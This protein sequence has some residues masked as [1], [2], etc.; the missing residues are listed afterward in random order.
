MDEP[1]KRR[2]R[3]AWRAAVTADVAAAQGGALSRAQLRARGVTRYDV[4]EEVAAGRWS[5][6][7]HQTVFIPPVEQE[8]ADRW[9]AVFEVGAGARLDGVTALLQAGLKGWSQEV[10][11]VSVPHHKKVRRVPGVRIHAVRALEA[12]TTH[13][14]P[15]TRTEIA[16]IRAAVW[17]VSDRQAATFIAMAV[18][19]RL[20]AKPALLEAWDQ[21]SYVRNAAFLGQIIRDVCAGAESLGELDFA[22][23][24]RQ[25][26]LPEPERQ[27]VRREGKSRVYLDVRWRDRAV[28]VEV[29]GAQHFSGLTPVDDALRQN[30]VVLGGDAV[31]RIPVLGLR[32]YESQFM[33]QV[34]AALAAE[35]RR[36]A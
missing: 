20:V 4:R 7:G 35:V 29:D 32:L 19:Q 8:L 10:I 12:L 2:P 16:T 28:V 6:R 26:G 11:D 13:A 23:L 21:M 1:S 22:R 34:R 31:L 14:L 33:E 18:Q 24:C 36:T 15:R 25:Y 3:R 9:S 5:V 27:V 30:A 17:A